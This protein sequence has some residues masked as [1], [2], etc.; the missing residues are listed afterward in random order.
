MRQG[1]LFS[2]SWT[3]LHNAR[4][5]VAVQEV[6]RLERSLFFNPQ[7]GEIL[8]KIA[9]RQN[10]E[11]AKLT[12]QGLSAEALTEQRIV[13][14]Y[15]QQI[16][17]PYKVLHVKIPII[18]DSATLTIY[19]SSYPMLSAHYELGENA[20][21]LRVLDNER[22][23]DEID[24]FIKQ[25]NDTMSK[26]QEEIARYEGQVLNAVQEAAKRRKAEI[27]EDNRRD[28]SRKFPVTRRA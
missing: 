26:L 6:E 17:I 8:E 7:L 19:P 14:D 18:G 25:V 22:A 21:A 13:N 16:T 24:S 9:A 15:G 2:Q 27:D 12:K 23:E 11:V 3:E 10:L 4:V 28:Q 20:I 5:R 1:R